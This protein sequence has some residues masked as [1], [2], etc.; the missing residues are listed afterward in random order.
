MSARGR[1]FNSETLYGSS[2]ARKVCRRVGDGTVDDRGGVFRTPGIYH[3]F[4]TTSGR[5]LGYLTLGR[6]SPHTLGREAQR[7]KLGN[8]AFP[9]VVGAVAAGPRFSR[10]ITVCARRATRGPAYG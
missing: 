10:N 8:D 5:R 7:I 1:R 2:G 3:A 4:E 9:K 6:K